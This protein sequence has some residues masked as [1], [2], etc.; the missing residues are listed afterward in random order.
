[1][2]CVSGMVCEIIQ[3]SDFSLKV[4]IP[5]GSETDPLMF[6]FSYVGGCVAEEH[7]AEAAQLL[8]ELVSLLIDRVGQSGGQAIVS[9]TIAAEAIGR[10][11]ESGPD[12]YFRQARETGIRE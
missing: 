11:E 4:P 12:C 5:K 6:W 2:L 10:G 8:V 7:R 3:L 1:M 9:V